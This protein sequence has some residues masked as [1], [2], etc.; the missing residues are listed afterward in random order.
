MKKLGLVAIGLV[1]ILAVV[2]ISGCSPEGTT[3]SGG[4][5]NLNSQ[6][7]GIWING[8]GKVQAVPDVAIISLGIESQEATVAEA[9]TKAAEAMDEVMKA[10]SDAGIAEKDIQTQY[11]NIQRVTRWDS[12]KEQE[13]VIGFRVTNMVTAKVRDV[14]KAGIVIDAVVGAGGD[15]TRIDSISFTVDDP[16]E[17]YAEAREKA[18]ADAQAKAEQLAEAA[19]VELGTPSYINESTY[20]PTPVYR[21]AVMEDTIAGSYVETS[22]SPGEM[23]I[24][25]NVQLAYNIVD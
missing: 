18:V 7:E 12:S 25:L 19:G 15:L 21:S 23:E 16:T 14:E 2:G 1:L 20:I 8:T 9:Q 4:T 6:Q 13:T 24:T 3:I 5:F 22:I 10:L 17:Y 11:F